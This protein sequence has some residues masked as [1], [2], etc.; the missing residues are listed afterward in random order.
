MAKAKYDFFKEFEI[1]Q[2]VTK[3]YPDLTCAAYSLYLSMRF[4]ESE[5][6]GFCNPVCIGYRDMAK[7]AHL[8]IGTIKGAINEL[9]EH[10]LLKL[11]IGEPGT[12]KKATKITRIPIEQ[13][14]D[15]TLDGDTIHRKFARA[16][17][18]KGV[19]I[20]GE[21]QY[22]Q[23]TIKQTNRIYSKNPNVQG[24]NKGERF[25]LLSIGAPSGSIL[26]SCDYKEAEPTVIK[27][28]IKSDHAIDLYKAVMDCTGWNRS[29]AKTETNHLTY[30]KN[31]VYRFKT[32]P[33]QARLDHVIRQYVNGL[34]RLKRDLLK[35]SQKSRSVTTL[36]GH[37]LSFSKRTK[38]HSGKI[39]NWKVQG[40]IADISASA[41][42]TLIQDKD[43]SSMVYLHDELIILFSPCG[44]TEKILSDYVQKVMQREA[45]KLSIPLSTSVNALTI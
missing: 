37:V 21:R 3:N 17:K 9:Q 13:L 14:E 2:Y 1:S 26:I 31:T 23:W 8:A 34:K 29:K 20:E 33:E 15:H 44:K 10:S 41:G 35:E 25:N 36:G 7:I 12:N 5:K 45:Q 28:L 30:S 43:I 32:W 24:L 11:E 38:P 18:E 16:L 19:L 6:F 4:M 27:S 22:P 42:Y 40:S 39:L